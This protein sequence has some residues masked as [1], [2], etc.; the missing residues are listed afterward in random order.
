[1]IS[2]VVAVADLMLHS[3]RKKEKKSLKQQAVNQTATVWRQK[4][5]VE[6]SVER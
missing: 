6:K 5:S 4:H 2:I 1:M 3:V